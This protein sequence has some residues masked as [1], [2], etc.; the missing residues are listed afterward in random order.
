MPGKHAWSSPKNIGEV[1]QVLKTL[2]F[3]HQ[4]LSTPESTGISDLNDKNVDI[5]IV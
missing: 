4:V 1:V 5:P 3:V 2:D